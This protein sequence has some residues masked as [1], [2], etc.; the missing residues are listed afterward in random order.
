MMHSDTFDKKNKI[1]K[2]QH[3]GE[4]SEAWHNKKKSRVIIL[5]SARSLDL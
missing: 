4:N 3:Y 2:R 5:R 1:E